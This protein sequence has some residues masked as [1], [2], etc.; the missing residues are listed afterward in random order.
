MRTV[1]D[2]VGGSEGLLR[3]A[4]A[5]HARVMADEVV[6]H[7]FGPGVRADHTRRLAAYWGQALGGPPA[8]SDSYGD[9]TSVVRIHSGNGPHAEM[10]DRA[11]A[12]FAQALADVGLAAD[13]G[14]GRVLAEYFA[15][16]TRTTMSRYHASADDVPAG[17][18][19]SAW[20]WDGPAVSAPDHSRDA[21]RGEPS[22]VDPGQRSMPAIH[23]ADEREMLTSM[24]DWYRA[25]VL[26][27]VGGMRQR[28]ATTSPLRSG[29]TAAGL[30]K[31]LAYVEDNW[32]THGLGRQPE[33]EPWSS[34]PFD[35][36]PDW[37]FHSANAEPLADSVEVYRSA[38]GRSRAVTRT[39]SLDDT[40]VNKRGREFSLRFVLLHLIEET[41]RH[42]GHLD[43]LRELA[44]GQTGD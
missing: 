8:Y 40:G 26:A 36:D 37:E 35:H 7:A 15:W 17:L 12:C 29:T 34:A 18:D 13:D 22:P 9:E 14:P 19:I 33:P 24:L 3:L 1:Y 21:E 5:W 20:S 6:S 42:L 23:T 38:C 44:D 43:V 27:K 28:D 41:A 31:H 4:D 39:L 10:D 32:F 16:A 25:G 30:V 11:I 2:A